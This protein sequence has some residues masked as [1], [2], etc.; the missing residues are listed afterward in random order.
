M[1]M[2]VIVAIILVA[3]YAHGYMLT[4]RG[5]SM[6][7]VPL[8]DTHDEPVWSSAVSTNADLNEAIVEVHFT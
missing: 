1:M 7:L 2:F 5:R 4:P 8:R 6:R 3:Q